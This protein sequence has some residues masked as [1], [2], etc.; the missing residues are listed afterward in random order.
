[1]TEAAVALVDFGFMQLGAS[2]IQASHATWNGA[3]RRVL[4]KAGL[5]F[6]RHVPEG[7]QKNGVWV[8]EDLLSITQEGVRE[9]FWRAIFKSQMLSI[10]T[11]GGGKRSMS[12]TKMALVIAIF[13]AIIKSCYRSLNC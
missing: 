12:S 10:G 2:A 6:L 7:F 1:M 4:E 8:A 5:R 9:G 3:S 13:S 11:H